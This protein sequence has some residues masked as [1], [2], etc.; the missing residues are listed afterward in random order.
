MNPS[1]PKYTPVRFSEFSFEFVI[2]INSRS[3][4]F[5]SASVFG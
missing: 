3:L 1:P 5:S 2:S 4:E